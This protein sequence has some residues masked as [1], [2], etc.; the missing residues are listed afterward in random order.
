MFSE[1]Q[2]NKDNRVFSTELFSNNRNVFNNASYVASFY[3]YN[4]IRN[5][6]LERTTDIYDIINAI[7]TWFR[8]EKQ[9]FEDSFETF[10]NNNQKYI[11][12]VVNS[13]FD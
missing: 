9:S 8:Q 2:N 7:A 10:Q 3:H 12:K 6:R 13:F 4:F 1:V 5:V 11:E